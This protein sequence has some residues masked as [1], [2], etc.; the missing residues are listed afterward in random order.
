MD[1]VSGYGLESSPSART[2]IGELATDRCRRMSLR[3]RK[4]KAIVQMLVRKAILRR[5]SKG[6]KT[7]SH[8][9]TSHR[10][11]GCLTRGPA[12][13]NGLERGMRWTAD[14]S[15]GRRRVLEVRV[16]VARMK[17]VVQSPVRMVRSGHLG[18]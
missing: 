1:G 14:R 15:Q 5:T 17:A 4:W 11:A 8:R 16:R 13:G 2:S 9:G 7:A 18:R 10:I 3:T 6:R 12:S